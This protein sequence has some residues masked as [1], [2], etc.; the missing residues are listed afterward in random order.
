MKNTHYLQMLEVR[1]NYFINE[2]TRLKD[3]IKKLRKKIK[4]K[5]SKCI[6]NY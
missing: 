6:N 5:C 1:L 3:V 4:E 2:N